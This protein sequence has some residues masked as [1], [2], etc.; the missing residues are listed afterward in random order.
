[1]EIV[2]ELDLRVA[3]RRNIDAIYI[4]NTEALDQVAGRGV[5]PSVPSG[6]GIVAQ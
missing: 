4:S 6:P 5:D 1:M 2:A 3:L